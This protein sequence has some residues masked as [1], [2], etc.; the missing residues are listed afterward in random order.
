MTRLI[1]QPLLLAALLAT[2]A[3][4]GNDEAPAAD[5]RDGFAGLADKAVTEIREEFATEDMDLGRGRNDEPAASEPTADYR[6]D[7]GGG[8]L[9][10]GE[11]LPAEREL[12]ERMGARA[13][14]I[15]NAG[16]MQPEWFDGVTVVGLT[17]GAS[18]PEILIQH[19]VDRL[20]EWGGEV[21]E[22]LA[23][24]PENVVF[25]MPRELRIPVRPV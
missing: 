16:Q 13:Y 11:R 6:E 19:V 23:G 1:A 20:C 22:E 17:A 24:R 3:C 25:S 4:S 5:A 8:I 18:A 2:A 12:A 7:R 14:L 15:D 9:R 21:P 10:P